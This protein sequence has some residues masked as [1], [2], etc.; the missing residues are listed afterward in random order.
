MH[1]YKKE[2]NMEIRVLKNFLTVAYENNVS[3]AAE[4][5]HLS[6][7]ALSRQILDLEKELGVKLFLRTNR[8]VELTVEGLRFRERAQAIVDLS[9][10]TIAEFN[11]RENSLFGEIRVALNTAYE[12]GSLKE[13]VE[14]M[15]QR[16]PNV[17]YSFLN[18][19]D[20]KAAA[21]L[22]DGTADFA[23]LTEPFEKEK[24]EYITLPEKKLMGILMRKNDPAA[25][26]EFVTADDLKKMRLFVFRD[27]IRPRFP[28]RPQVSR[29]QLHIQGTFTSLYTVLPFIICGSVNA[30]CLQ[31]E[32]EMPAHD[33]LVFLPL[34]PKLS[35]ETVLAWRKYHVLS[36][37]AEMF[38]SLFRESYENK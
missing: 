6:Q 31:S 10:Q 18:A 27:F 2:Q 19:E 23:F 8:S 7:S 13:T 4:S 24:H 34:S 21:Y 33:D 22:E 25:G 30:L 16:Y 1:T 3:K 11:D 15:Q 37:Q 9:E 14:A 20:G 35:F 12:T 36:A 38:L 29:S 32:R 17:R 26:K 28:K 5:L